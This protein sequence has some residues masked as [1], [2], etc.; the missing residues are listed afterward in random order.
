MEVF[1]SKMEG[2]WYRMPP[3]RSSKPEGVA[4]VNQ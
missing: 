3:V 4:S 1:D 2:R